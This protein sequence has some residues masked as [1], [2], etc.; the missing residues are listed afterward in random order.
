M[1]LLIDAGNTRLKWLLE[2]ES[3]VASD[4]QV[5][6]RGAC[7]VDIQEGIM[8]GHDF[9]TVEA[10]DAIYVASV[11]QSSFNYAL[12]ALLSDCFS[13]PIEFIEV[14]KRC[15]GLQCAY[16]DV[17]ALGVDRWLGMLALWAGRAAVQS[18]QAFCVVSLGTAVTCDVVDG[19]GEHQGGYITLGLRSG[20]HALL[21]KTDKIQ[22][23]D[24][25]LGRF[26]ELGVDTL[27]AV[28]NG[29]LFALVAYVNAL[30]RS[31][32]VLGDEVPLYLTGGDAELLAPHLA[33]PHRIVDG[34]VFEGMRVVIRE[35]YAK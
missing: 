25:L 31:Y 11:R 7:S 1:R 2:S 14:Q 35:N 9:P 22:A 29:A 32:G 19:L 17:S 3:G 6:S 27:T 13:A 10:L 26:V 18:G 5:L 16:S 33:T 12:E 30:G 24:S 20:V 21:S 23:D 28:N 15:A 4:G 8:I 34:L